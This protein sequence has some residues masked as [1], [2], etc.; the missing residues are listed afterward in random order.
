MTD[1]ARTRDNQCHKL[2]LYQLNYSHHISVFLDSGVS[3]G[4]RTP[5]P[6]LRRALLYPAELQTHSVKVFWS[7]KRGSNS[8]HSAW[9]AD[10]L[11]TELFPHNGRNSKI[12]TCGPLLPRQMRYRTAL[13][14]DA[15]SLKTRMIISFIPLCVNTFFIFLK[16]F[17]NF[18]FTHSKRSLFLYKIVIVF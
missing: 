6:R 17:F 18:I 3:E 7:G 13:Y 12:R 15:F 9:K 10:A 14:S 11:P 1:E 4:I 2:A 16:N 8:R 5:D